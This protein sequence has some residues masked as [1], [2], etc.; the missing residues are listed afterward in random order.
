MSS[1]CW[2]LLLVFKSFHFKGLESLFSSFVWTIKLF[3]FPRIYNK[4]PNWWM[5]LTFCFYRKA[6]FFFA[7]R[8]GRKQKSS[9]SDFIVQIEWKANQIT[10]SVDYERSN[11]S[12]SARL[13]LIQWNISS[14]KV[15]S[16]K[17]NLNRS[18]KRKRNFR[19]LF[20]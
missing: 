20:L 14:G 9:L 13:S 7:G 18:R 5:E 6:F 1:S 19:T 16:R 12:L 11:N 3:F 17:E 10:F 15:Q 8:N 4:R 2:K